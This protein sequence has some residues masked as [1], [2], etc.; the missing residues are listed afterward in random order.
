MRVEE[1]ILDVKDLLRKRFGDMPADIGLLEEDHFP[2]EE[3]DGYDYEDEYKEDQEEPRGENDQSQ[4]S[5]G[6]I[7]GLKQWQVEWV[8][9]VEKLCVMDAGWGWD[10]F[11]RMVVWNLKVSHGGGVMRFFQ[12]STN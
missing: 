8:E 5:L 4:Q 9:E 2:P 11:W 1:S 10:G 3:V 6:E 7:L 12:R